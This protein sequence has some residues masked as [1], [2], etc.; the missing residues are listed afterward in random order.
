MEFFIIIITMLIIY[1]AAKIRLTIIPILYKLGGYFSSDRK[2]GD[3]IRAEIL[4]PSIVPDSKDD[5]IRIRQESYSISWSGF[6]SELRLPAFCSYQNANI[7]G[8]FLFGEIVINGV[9]NYK[10]IDY[11]KY[12][13]IAELVMRQ[14]LT[15]EANITCSMKSYDLIKNELIN[16]RGITL[17]FSAAR[18]LSKSDKNS[19]IIGCQRVLIDLEN[20]LGGPTKFCKLYRNFYSNNE[21]DRERL[22][23]FEK[24][25]RQAKLDI[26]YESEQ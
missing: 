14:R 22:E 12:G 24:N 13:Y 10:E 9:E 19:S 21:L 11:G 2:N 23:D 6:N 8:S 16:D 5:Q 15:F 18:S 4:I 25:Y 17:Y 1:I 20:T 7:S 3:F 26:K